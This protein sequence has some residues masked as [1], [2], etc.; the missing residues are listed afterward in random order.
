MSGHSK[1]ANIKHRK[2][3]ADAKK[4]KVFSKIAKEIMVTARTSGGDPAG[5][6]TLRALIQKARSANM[7]ADNIERAIKKGMGDL[8]GVVLE[9][10]VYEGYGPG[11][12]AIIIETL[13]DNKNRTAAEVKH[14]FSKFNLSLAG[15]GSVSRSF[16]RKGQIIIDQETADED[17]VMELALDAGAEDMKIEDGAYE[18]VTPPA[19]FMDVV[20]ALNGANIPLASSE[21]T[22]IPDSYTPVTDKGHASSVMR[23]IDALED[24]DDVQNV[25]SNFDIDDAMM[26]AISVED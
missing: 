11:G 13:T 9:E 24:L 14:A 17:Q 1:W 16:Q 4:G 20:D 21:I 5:N 12:V 25:Y 8:D 22:M 15:P 18:V 2:G 7:P 19:V 23:F 10:L 26:E 6:I 3:A